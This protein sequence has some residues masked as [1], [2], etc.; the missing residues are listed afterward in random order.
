MIKKLF[1]LLSCIP[2]WIVYWFSFLSLRDKTIVISG[3]HTKSFSG[4]VKALFL[5]K[6]D[7]YRQIFISNDKELISKLKNQ[8]YEAYSKYS[9][10]G[11]LYSLKAGN[12]IY[13]SYPSDISFWLSNGAKYINVWHGTPI[14]KIERDITTGFYSLRNKHPWLYNI[15]NPAVLAKP[16]VLL[17]TS[18]YE[19]KCFQS[20]FDVEENIF[21]EAYPP[22]LVSIRNYQTLDT[23]ENKHILYAPTWRDDHSFSFFNHINIE[24][25]NAF[26]SNNNLIFS[27]KLHPSDKTP[28]DQQ[29]FTH[30]KLIDKDEDVYDYLREAKIV[31]SDYSSM[32]FEALY[33]SKPTVL[34]CPDYELY[35]TNSREFYIDPCKD[36]PVKVPLTQNEL[37]DALLTALQETSTVNKRFKSFK[38]YEIED[39]I[40]EKLIEK[41]HSEL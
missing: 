36:L 4:N 37:E 23:E 41:A 2:G 20:A 12:Y 32:I 1:T 29:S 34:F 27:I 30:I 11:I 8:G 28:T 7:Q 9:L 13:S 24:S 22:R 25:F 39:K 5:E 38:P 31:V 18:E 26:L 33:L 3:V 17:V 15:L 14:K 19:K 21:V 10:Q 35:Q 16:D 40:L 6:S